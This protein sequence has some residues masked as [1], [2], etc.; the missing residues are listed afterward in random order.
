MTYHEGARRHRPRVGPDVA[1]ARQLAAQINGQLAS[2][3]PAALSFQPVLIAELRS[4]WLSHHEDIA[5][6]SLQTVRRYRAATEHLVR[7]LDQTR[8]PRST[9]QFRIDQAELFVRYL[10]SIQVHP[11]GHANSTRRPLLD[12]GIQFILEACRAMFGY[13]IK[14][15]H[16]SPYSENPFA[17]LR[18]EKM[19]IE[20]SKRIELFTPEEETRFLEA[21]DAWQ[22]PIFVTLMLTGLRPS[23][24]TH[25]LLPDDVDWERGVLRIRNKPALGW[26]VKTRNEREIPLVP[27]LRSFLEQFV[28]ER[29][30]GPLFLRRR[31]S[32]GETPLLGYAT[33]REM[34]QV[35]RQRHEAAESV[36]DVS[37][38]EVRSKVLRGIW[39]DAGAI[40]AERIRE[41]FMRV[42]RRIGLSEQTCP[43]MLRH[44]FATALQDANVDPLIR[45]EVM[46]HVVGGHGGRDLG[47]TAVYTHTRATTRLAQLSE[48]MRERPACMLIRQSRSAR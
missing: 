21:C 36:D 2:H 44:L 45:N 18:L 24:L 29:T 16:L 7:F 8:T 47:M 13:A 35:A 15:R 1:G 27:P 41:E 19:P 6:S 43:K 12:K 9:E 10:R 42:C 40:R 23:E 26:Q 4:R 17:G 48:A 33:F 14:R 25:I 34:E 28:G 32:G 46:G 20:N 5:R 30:A 22:L 31:F 3:A 37:N 38:G 39:R 11:N